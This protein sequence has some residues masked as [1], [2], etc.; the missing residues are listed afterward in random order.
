MKL[1]IDTTTLEDARRLMTVERPRTCYMIPLDQPEPGQFIPS[2]VVENEPGHSPMTGRGD[3]AAPWIW[4]STLEEAQAVCDSVNARQGI[5]KIDAA[6][7]VC[8]S[9]FA[10]IAEREEQARHKVRE[11]RPLYAIAADIRASWPNVNYAAKPYLDA[12][13]ELN[14]VEDNYS[15]DSAESIIAYF[16][17]NAR[18]WRGDDARRIKAELKGMLR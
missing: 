9:M 5:S 6:E 3:H 12:L 11:P 2:L 10:R 14:S 4:G 18:S 17:G 16:L 7:I 15:F 8:S 13:A 1:D